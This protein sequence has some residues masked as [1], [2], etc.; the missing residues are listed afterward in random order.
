MKCGFKSTLATII[1]GALCL[2]CAK[3]TT[4]T[5]SPDTVAIK[6]RSES[7][8]SYFNSHDAEKLSQLWTEDGKYNNF[9]T[10]ET[11]VGKEA[12]GQYFKDLFAQDTSAKLKLTID[13]VNYRAPQNMIEKGFAEFTSNG[14]KEKFAFKADYVNENNTWLLKK[15]SQIFVGTAPS[16]YEQLKELNWLSGKWMDEDTGND[17][18]VETTYKWEMNKN[19]LVQYFSKKILGQKEIKGQQIIGWDPSQNQIRSWIFDSDGGYGES[20][21]YKDGDSWYSTMKYTLENGKKASS[22]NVYTKIDD[23]TYNYSLESRDV[24]GRL[25][26]NIGPFKIVREKGITE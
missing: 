8:A 9:T 22:T 14:K 5:N 6:Q 20:I 11:I 21:W 7:Y 12:I 2:S 1:L 4:D 16:H 13:S 15:V 23:N 18:D 19:F 3:H 24:D 17:M 26:P 25:L 10:R